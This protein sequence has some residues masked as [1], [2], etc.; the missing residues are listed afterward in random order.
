MKYKTVLSAYM[1]MFIGLHIN[2][3]WKALRTKVAIIIAQLREVPFVVDKIVIII[4]RVL[5]TVRH[6]LCE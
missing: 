2:I 4:I 6:L 1:Y 5:S 3:W